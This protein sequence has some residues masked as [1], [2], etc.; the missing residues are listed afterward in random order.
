MTARLLLIR[1]GEPV[2][3]TGR[4][5]GHYDTE[6]VPAATD[7]LRRAAQIA[8]PPRLVVSSDL[9][10]AAG[11]AAILARAWNAELRFDPRL[12]ELSF[13]DWEGHLWSDISRDDA[14]AME[15]WGSDWTRFS[16][17][18]GESGAELAS[19]A[20]DA[21][22]DL[23][24]LARSSS[25]DVAVVSHAGWIRVAITILLDE[26]LLSAFDRT[27]DYAHAAIV[28]IGDDNATGVYWN[29]ETLD[30]ANAR[31]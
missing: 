2:G 4:C 18:H 29:L 23:T 24:A 16:A 6:L 12:R 1:H 30:V 8:K 14:E 15:R 28:E 9:R 17:P 13:G 25:S 7:T 3:H 31:A 5:V 27:I 22:D 21:L 11:S 26:P 20:R 10:R 19:R